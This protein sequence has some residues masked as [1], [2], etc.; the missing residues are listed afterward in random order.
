MRTDRGSRGGLRWLIHRDRVNR[1][2]ARVNADQDVSQG[3][4]KALDGNSFGL[5]FAVPFCQTCKTLRRGRVPAANGGVEATV[6]RAH[7]PVECVSRRDSC[8]SDSRVTLIALTAFCLILCAIWP[9]W[10]DL[11]DAR[12]RT[13]TSDR[14]NLSDL[15]TQAGASRVCP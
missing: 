2:R 15:P 10:A 6:P 11:T 9:W 3:I 7:G 1:L 5:L 14:A 8:G 13:V 4:R 12:P